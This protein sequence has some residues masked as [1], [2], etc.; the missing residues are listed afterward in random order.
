MR[1]ARPLAALE[2]SVAERLAIARGEVVLAAVSGGSD[3]VALAGIASRLATEAGATL[4]LAHVNHGLRPG[5][6]QDEAVVL[7]LAMRLGVP[8]EACSIEVP[9]RSEAA[10]RDARYRALARIARERGARRVLTAHHAA[11]QTET[12]LLA[13]FRGTGL[14]GL[15]GMAARRDLADGVALERPLLAV[16][17]ADLRAYCVARRLPYALDPSND[18]LAYRRNAVRASL[19]PLR[20]SFPHLDRAVARCAEIVRDERAGRATP[21]AALRESVRVALRTAT[22]DLLDL[23]FERADAAA[24][25]L[26][27]GAPGRHFL[28]RGV[29]LI[30]EPTVGA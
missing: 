25:A 2:A 22:G 5:A 3:S 18:D 30:I 23:P 11:D 26:E 27:D 15:A 28:R 17:P 16:E 29:E 10:A 24:R 21:R 14:D 7:A 20:A 1:G 13:L 12:V 19:A 6:W 4:V 8:V 9:G